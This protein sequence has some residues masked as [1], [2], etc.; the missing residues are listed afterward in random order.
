MGNGQSIPNN[1][2]RQNQLIQEI[3]AVATDLTETYSTKFLDPKF[4]TTI[5]L[6][7]NDK[8][9]NFR[10]HDLNNVSMTLGL[11]A[12][13]PEQK[14]QLCSKIVQH[15][16]DRVNLIAAIQQSLNYCSNRIFAL[17]SGPRCEG[18]P[19]IFDQAV[20]TQS[21]GRWVS[22]ITPP[23]ANVPEN[24][25]WYN[26]LYH[27]QS[28]YL[29]VLARMLDIL[30]QLRDFDEDINDERLKM[31]GLEVEQLIDIMQG[32][33]YQM[34]QLILTTPTF[35]QGELRKQQEDQQMSVQ[36]SSARLAALR[37]ARGLPPVQS[38]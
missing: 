1:I 13:I 34:Y 18:N 38:Q 36:E 32:T 16:T 30:K 11:V 12:D 31:L 3:H 10:K 7:Y 24:K 28:K 20:C 9:M 19:E 27:M 25:L 8:L 2:N 5:A 23:D 15:Y 21:N 22:A 33:C 26:Y 14:Q 6:I 29:E 4:C 37:A 17:T 35:T